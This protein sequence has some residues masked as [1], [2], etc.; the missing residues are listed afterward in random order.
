MN[1]LRDSRSPCLGRVVDMIAWAFDE[2]DEEGENQ[3]VIRGDE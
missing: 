3:P 1:L 2:D